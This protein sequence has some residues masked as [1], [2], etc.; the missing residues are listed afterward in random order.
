MKNNKNYVSIIEAYKKKGY[1]IL[2][3]KDLGERFLSF[4]Y[5]TTIM[6]APIM[7]WDIIMLAVLGSIVSIAGIFI[8]NCIIGILL[9]CS[10]IGINA[11][12]YTQTSGQSLGMR[13][14]HY[15]VINK[16]G[17]DAS[18]KQL[19]LREIVGFNIPFI[20]LML[21]TNIFGVLIFYCLNAIVV[22]ISHDQ[23]SIIDYIMKLRVIKLLPTYEEDTLSTQ[24]QSYRPH[25][26]LHIHSNFSFNGT[27]NVEE[28]FQIAKKKE[29]HTISITDVDSAK[30]NSIA[31][32][33]SKMYHI[34]YVP[35]IE[36]NCKFE[37]HRL[38]VL[39]YFMDYSHE[40]FSHIENESLV[41]EKNAS[42]TRIRKFASMINQTI[43]IDRLLMNN[44][45]QKIPGELIA[46]HVLSH[47]E[48]K[49]NPILQTYLYGSKSQ[50]GIRQLYKDY[51]AYGKSCF[52]Q[53]K[54]PELKDIL[55]VVSLTNGVS[56]LAYPGKFLQQNPEL[57]EKLVPMGIQGVEVFYSKHS[58]AEM[59]AVLK[60]AMKHKLFITGG[61]GFF[62][63]HANNEIGV[64][65]T[66]KEGEELIMQFI[67]AKL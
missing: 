8:V 3:K 48:Y 30:A 22:L 14:F 24:K 16:D 15:R 5:D 12:I 35:G 20:V 29:L 42:I 59:A 13:L 10:I 53:V 44:R 50:D 47:S 60:F 36:I 1:R 34:R 2:N 31:L 45:F 18:N 57:M 9:A 64:T 56:V 26:D 32:R 52:V 63:P 21:F 58:R 7:I 51:F 66:P 41:N 33:M 38:R 17:A 37:G 28:I 62:F 49:D 40:L 65:N 4:C 25:I 43:D 27:R 55:D 67:N 54:Y 11:Y 61:S 6:L 39:A 23:C 19:I 46:K